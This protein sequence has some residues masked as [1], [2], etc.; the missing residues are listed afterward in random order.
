MG[1][2]RQTVQYHLQKHPEAGHNKPSLG[3]NI[4]GTSTKKIKSSGKRR[5]IISSVQN[6]TEVVPQLLK[7]LEALADHYGAEIMVATYSYNKNSY[8]PMAVKWHTEDHIEE[9]W[10][11]E[12]ILKYVVDERVELAPGLI[13]YGE[14]NI[15]PTA[16]DPLKQLRKFGGRNSGIFPHAKQAFRTVPTVKHQDAKELYTTGTLTKMNYIQKFSGFRAE[17]DHVYGAVIVEVDEDGTWFVRQLNADSKWRIYDFDVCVDN[18]TVTTGNPLAGITWGDIH[19]FHLEHAIREALWGIGGMLDVLKPKHQIFHD[20]L[21]FRSRNHH[22]K[23]NF[24]KRFALWVKGKEAVADEL[25][26]AAEFLRFADRKWCNSVVVNSNHDRALTRWLQQ[27]NYRSDPIN[28]EIFLEL[29]LKVLRGIKQENEIHVLGEALTKFGCPPD[30][31]F[32]WQ[33]ESYMVK[34][35][36]CG[37]HGDEGVNGSKATAEQMDQLGVRVNMGDK[38]SPAII[39]GVFCV[40]VTGALDQGY[41]TGPSSWARAHCLIYPNGKRSMIVMKGDRWKM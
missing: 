14:A 15:L 12:S 17:F 10:Y 9:L 19:E 31:K 27:A 34:D 22:D 5:Y 29:E 35:I 1:I 36:E 32:L 20:L 4:S 30:T 39:G 11:D 18:G 33:D 26:S 41:N 6:N 2:T 40:G 38:H 7:N 25:Q 24:H 28:A 13:W 8:G 37:M 3:G 16:V 21:D 23:D